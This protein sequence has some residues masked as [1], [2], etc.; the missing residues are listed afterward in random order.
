[1]LK[2]AYDVPAAVRYRSVQPDPI[3]VWRYALNAILFLPANKNWS[4][5][6][7]ES[8][9]SAKSMRN[10]RN[11][12]NPLSDHPPVDSLCNK[13]QGFKAGPDA[14]C[15]QGAIRGLDQVRRLDSIPE[16]KNQNR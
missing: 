9:A 10:F 11:K 1:M 7:V 6:R 8:S 3:S 12:K 14:S 16:P 4:T 15:P 13:P 5:L 2:Q